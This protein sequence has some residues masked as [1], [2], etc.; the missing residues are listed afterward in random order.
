[1]PD[2]QPDKQ[3]GQDIAGSL[4]RGGRISNPDVILSRKN[5]FDALDEL[6]KESGIKRGTR[7]AIKWYR[8]LVRELFDLSDV[9]PEETFLR[10]E[11]RLIQKSGMRRRT[12]R[13]F[14]FNYIP[15]TRSTLKYYDSVPLVYILKFTKDGFLGLNLHYLDIRLRTVLFNNLQILLSG[16]IESDFTRLR[17]NTEILKGSRKFRYYRPCIR[18]YKTKYIGSRILQIPPKDWGVAIHLPIE[19]FKK[20]NKYQVWTESRRKLVQEI[21][22]SKEA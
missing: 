6:F 20:K 15:K 1:M 9:S 13:M 12:G 10:D 14:L 4:Y 11:S 22:G 21:E 16:P 2:E 18:N 3:S 19:R 5:V 17:I 7:D 8:E